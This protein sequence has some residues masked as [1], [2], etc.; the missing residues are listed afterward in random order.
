MATYLTCTSK[1]PASCDQL[2]QQ[3]DEISKELTK[4][5]SIQMYMCEF[6]VPSIKEHPNCYGNVQLKQNC[7]SSIST[8]LFVFLNKIYFFLTLNN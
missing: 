7:V 6:I 5:F 2:Q 3:T 4:W 8:K 1:Y